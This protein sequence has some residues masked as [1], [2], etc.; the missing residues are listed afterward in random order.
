M[1]YSGSFRGLR[2]Y[3]QNGGGYL[4]ILADIAPATLQVLNPGS[5]SGGATAPGS[6]A[7][8][9]VA[10]LPL[11]MSSFF[12]AGRLLKDMGKTVVSASRTFRKVQAVVN[13]GATSSA[14]F[15]VNGSPAYATFYLESGNEGA[16]AAPARVVRFM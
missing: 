5:G 2:G 9:V 1:A 16:G 15:G 8:A 12:T 4:M 13:A 3:S 6:F 11:N 7:P 10:D 14:T